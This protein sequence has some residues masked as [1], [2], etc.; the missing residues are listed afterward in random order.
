M[1]VTCHGV[2][3][4]RTRAPVSF[5]HG[6]VV[7]GRLHRCRK[8]RH[9]RAR[10][11][12]DGPDRSQVRRRRVR[13]PNVRRMDVHTIWPTSEYNNNNNNIIISCPCLHDVT[14]AV[15]LLQRR[16]TS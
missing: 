11:M 4:G 5:V 13:T 10:G 6:D 12:A 2:H 3:V 9:G 8:L 1:A 15:T 7:D 14:V 16:L